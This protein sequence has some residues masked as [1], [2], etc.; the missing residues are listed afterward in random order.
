MFFDGDEYDP[1]SV[2]FQC[3]DCECDL[4]Q[5]GECTNERC[6]QFRKHPLSPG[7]KGAEE[8]VS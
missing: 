3:P 6:A 5:E 1:M 2:T 7:F 4:S 8:P